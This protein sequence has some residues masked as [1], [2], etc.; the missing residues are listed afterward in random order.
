[1]PKYKVLITIN[2]Y[3][4]VE[5]YD[6]NHAEEMAICEYLDGKIELSSMPEF[7]C[8]ECDLIEEEENA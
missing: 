2:E 4:I 8:E 3:R 6:A 7:V 5:A 1:M